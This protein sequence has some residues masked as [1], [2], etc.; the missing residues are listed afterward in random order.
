M[1]KPDRKYLLLMI[2]GVSAM[3]AGLAFGDFIGLN[4]VKWTPPLGIVDGVVV[5]VPPISF[6]QPLPNNGPPPTSQTYTPKFQWTAG[7]ANWRCCTP[8]NGSATCQI[9]MHD[10][11]GNHPDITSGGIPTTG[12]KGQTGIVTSNDPDLPYELDYPADTYQT[13]TYTAS[14]AQ[15]NGQPGGWCQS[16]LPVRNAGTNQQ[17]PAPVIPQFYSITIT[18]HGYNAC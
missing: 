3:T 9:T 5:P 1:R 14:L 16:L 12:G 2:A 7:S 17:T 8:S 6:C 10:N 4:T 13:Y 18:L 11:Q 15:A